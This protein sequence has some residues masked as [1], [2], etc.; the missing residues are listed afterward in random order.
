MSLFKKEEEVLDLTLM[1]RKGLLKKAE[2]LSK[3]D[4]GP[5]SYVNLST[6]SPP[7][8]SPYT[9]SSNDSPNPLSF[10]DT[11]AASASS[12][13]SQLDSS[14]SSSSQSESSYFGTSSDNSSSTSAQGEWVG[15][16]QSIA[17]NSQDNT[18]LQNK[19][20]DLEYKLDRLMDKIALIE[21]K[22]NDFEDKVT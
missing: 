3:L 15:T 14:S 9:E 2:E 20:D 4:R 8:T 7:T 1:Q 18:G 10:L 17:Q 19:L 13:A 22:V 16:N 5:N 11:F 21:N 12:T 6:S